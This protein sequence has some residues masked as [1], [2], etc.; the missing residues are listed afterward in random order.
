MDRMVSQNN[1]SDCIIDQQRL[2]NICDRMS[3]IEFE[4]GESILNLDCWPHLAQSQLNVGKI[5][6]LYIFALS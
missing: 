4:K 6:H 5:S 3:G 1:I 2:G